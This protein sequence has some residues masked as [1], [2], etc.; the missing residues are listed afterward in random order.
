MT[1]VFQTDHS[2]ARSVCSLAQSIHR[3]AHSLL[4]LP[5]GMVKILDEYE[6]T[7]KTRYLG[8]IMILVVETHPKFEA[9]RE[10]EGIEV[11]SF[12][13]MDKN[14]AGYTGQDGAPGVINS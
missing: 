12:A 5:H 13:L 4:S 8:I 6:C 2:V 10:N 11:T 9:T 7:Q 1:I 3:I 14:K